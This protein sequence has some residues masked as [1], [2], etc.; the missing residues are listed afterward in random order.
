[1]TYTINASLLDTINRAVW[2][3]NEKPSKFKELSLTNDNTKE[4][5]TKAFND[6]VGF[7]IEDENIVFTAPR[8]TEEINAIIEDNNRYYRSQVNTLKKACERSEKNKVEV[9][10]YL[11]RMG[12]DFLLAD[13]K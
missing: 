6:C 11:E 8:T 12:L 3:L 2:V 7:V 9:Y 10:S 1:M 5:F 13:I 4:D